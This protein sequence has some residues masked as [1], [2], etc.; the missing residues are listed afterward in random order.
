[1]LN[2]EWAANITKY[3]R[4][5]SQ[6][7]IGKWAKRKKDTVNVKKSKELYK[8]EKV[9]RVYYRT[10]VNNIYKVTVK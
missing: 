4:K 8:K 2:Y 6:G 9:I 3:L 5:P 1:M 10:Y 7:Q